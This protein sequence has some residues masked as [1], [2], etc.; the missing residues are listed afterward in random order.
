M[1]K[2][3]EA[4]PFRE[5]EALERQ[6]AAAERQATAEE[7]LAAAAEG[8][9]E[10]VREGSNTVHEF[11]ELMIEALEDPVGRQ[12]FEEEMRRHVGQGQ[13]LGEEIAKRHRQAR[14]F[15]EDEE[16]AAPA[17]T[18]TAQPAPAVDDPE[19]ALGL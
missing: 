15:V 3:K 14:R 16:V 17:S 1:S 2:E 12:M 19:F 18:A 6:A 13:E 4:L 7:R 8:I 9:L 11:S 10:L 5:V